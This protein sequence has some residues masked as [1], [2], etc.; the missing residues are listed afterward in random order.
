MSTFLTET[1]KQ[2][3]LDEMLDPQKVVL[4]CGIHN[5][6]YGSKKPPVFKCPECWKASFIGLIANTPPN[7][8][9]EVMEMLEYSIH[10]LVE[11]DKNGTIDRIKLFNHPKVSI[12]K[13][14]HNG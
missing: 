7:R 2:K 13:D 9:L 1:D 3:M 14:A 4:T 12:E 6:S 5:W 8:R 10:K 11:A